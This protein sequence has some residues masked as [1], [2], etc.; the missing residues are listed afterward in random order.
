MT[1]L[2]YAFCFSGFGIIALYFLFLSP[3]NEN[4][5]PP[6][7]ATIDQILIIPQNADTA[8]SIASYDLPF[9]DISLLVIA[10]DNNPNDTKS[11]IA[12][13]T[14]DKKEADGYQRFGEFFVGTDETVTYQTPRHRS[15]IPRDTIQTLSLADQT[16]LSSFPL[17]IRESIWKITMFNYWFTTTSW[18]SSDWKTQPALM[19]TLETKDPLSL[20]I[21]KRATIWSDNMLI[22]LTTTLSDTLIDF[23]SLQDTLWSDLYLNKDIQL[24]IYNTSPLSARITAS[25]IIYDFSWRDDMSTQQRWEETI[26][27]YTQNET[28]LLL[29]VQG[30]TLYI[31]NPPTSN[32][33]TSD[34]SNIAD[35]ETIVSDSAL[36][37]ITK[38]NNIA[39]YITLTT[40]WTLISWEM[41]PLWK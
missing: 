32:V 5:L 27:L 33:N 36:S 41:R 23:F 6:L 22:S 8:K 20:P 18:D 31:N 14:K 34:N 29:T 17:S 25:N 26:F 28:Q 2:A 37:F 16:F 3:K 1:A 13:R 40:S 35:L 12:W 39:Q 38:V 19:F 4:I 24:T 10:Q 21:K 9:D 11:I 15:Y 7:P 30:D